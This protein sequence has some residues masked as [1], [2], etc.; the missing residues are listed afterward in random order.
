MTLAAPVRAVAGEAG[1]TGG[2]A[3]LYGP[4]DAGRLDPAGVHAGPAA[5]IARLLSR[6][7]VTYE[8]RADLRDWQ[9]ICPVPDVALHVPSTYNAGLGAS[10][11][12]YVAHLRPGVL[13]DTD[14]PRPVTA[15]DFVRGFKRMANPVAP[16]PALAYFAGT[17]RGMAE[18]HAGFAA[19]MPPGAADPARLAAYQNANEIAGVFALDDET[20]VIEL[21]RPAPEF[22][23][24]LALPCASAAPVEYDAFVPGS[25]ELARNLRSNGP[26]RLA[27]PLTEAG[28]RLERNPAWSRDAD[29]VRAAHVDRVEIARDAADAAQMSAA[30]DSGAADVAW[31]PPLRAPGAGGPDQ[32]APPV[33]WALDP[34][35]VFNLA[36]GAPALGDIRVRRAIAAAIDRP[37]LA[38]LY[39]RHA[40]AADVRV[41]DR[42]VPPN[43]DPR[44]DDG[45]RAPD[46]GGGATGLTLTAVHR[47]DELDERLARAYAADL[48]RIGIGVRLAAEDEAV[49]WDLR[50]G[51]WSA[52]W[53]YRNGRAFL[54]PLL[55]SGSPANLG[56]YADAEVDA[57]IERALELAVEPPA[58]A[59]AAW[60]AV[61]RRALEDAAIVPL[62][63]GA[64]A[65]PQRCS[66]RTRD[67][68]AVPAL[69][70][71]PDLATLWLDDGGA[72][73]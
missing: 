54:Q 56:G 7:L 21:L 32:G 72:A 62:L 8:P 24:L 2:T 47:R 17:V 44:A 39:R 11:R 57:L 18:F 31:A 58:V 41:A 9:A 60:R 15:P 38:A 22:A 12:S 3:R 28:L 14:P 6:Q 46:D 20:L 13:W 53:R 25:P 64:P 71:A 51:S 4:G 10:H 67:A 66:D 5:V 34:Y 36:D 52:P 33:G 23:D 27:G 16:S 63:F 43:N 37:A 68:R 29:P 30:L 42:I 69:G 26:Y 45:I 50:T 61:E 1:R 70:Y 73:G 65:V 35:L 59:D 49:A 48:E 19:A 40:G 55:R